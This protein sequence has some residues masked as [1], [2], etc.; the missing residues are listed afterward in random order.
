M[1]FGPRLQFELRFDC[2]REEAARRIQAALAEAETQSLDATNPIR[3]TFEDDELCAIS[4]LSWSE[5]NAEIAGRLET[6]AH[7]RR[8]VLRVEVKT[9]FEHAFFVPLV[10]FYCLLIVVLGAELP[11]VL[12]LPILGI[13]PLSA[14]WVVAWTRFSVRSNRTREALTRLLFPPR[15]ELGPYRARGGT[16]PD[17][18]ARTPR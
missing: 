10:T 2:E 14:L 6:E 5:A 1:S 3:G 15:R 4:W 16:L 11:L 7:D 18:N 13:V 17:A 9:P 12:A 8:A